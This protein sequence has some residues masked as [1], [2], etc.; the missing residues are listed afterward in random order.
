MKSSRGGCS[1][2]RTRSSFRTST[3][4]KA[5]VTEGDAPQRRPH[6]LAETSR[7]SLPTGTMKLTREEAFVWIPRL[8]GIGMTLFLAAFALDA[9][10]GDSNLLTAVVG[11]A[12]GLLP[13][14]MALAT[15]VVGWKHE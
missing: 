14:I 6:E 15:V 3:F 13:A 11:L 8:Y 2:S 5:E 1:S 4:E 9:I 7:A 12:M 10:G